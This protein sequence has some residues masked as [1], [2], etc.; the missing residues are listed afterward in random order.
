MAARA[1]HQIT[2]RS[3]KGGSEPS[4]TFVGAQASFQ[5][6][7]GRGKG[8]RVADHQIELRA[9]CAQAFQHVEGV[10]LAGGEAVGKA[11]SLGALPGQRQGRGRGINGENRSRTMRQSRQTK[12]A[13]MGEHIQHASALGKASREG[14]VRTLVIEQPG[15]LASGHV[16]QIDSPV[17]R[18]LDRRGNAPHQHQ[19]FLIEPL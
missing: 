7:L 12:A 5:R 6:R 16:S 2:A 10:A 13:D 14:M 11:R 17:H 19:I 15:F 3:H 9:L 8:G 18:H 1:E 4:D